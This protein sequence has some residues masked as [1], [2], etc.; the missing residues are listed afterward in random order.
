MRMRER[1]TAHAQTQKGLVI[2]RGFPDFYWV[3]KA[4]ISRQISVISD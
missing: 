1:Y 2:S 4:L 3:F